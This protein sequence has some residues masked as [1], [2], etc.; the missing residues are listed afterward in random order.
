MMDTPTIIALW[1]V[2]IG[3]YL[4]GRHVDKLKKKYND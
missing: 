2:G 1:V 3:F 4:L